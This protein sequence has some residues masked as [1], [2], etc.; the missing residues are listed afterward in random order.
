MVVTSCRDITP[1]LE[2]RGWKI[3]WASSSRKESCMGYKAMQPFV[4]WGTS[5]EE[6][7]CKVS[8]L[9]SIKPKHTKND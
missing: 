7:V 2:S 4:P 5:P 9:D 3:K 1:R 8:I 6:S